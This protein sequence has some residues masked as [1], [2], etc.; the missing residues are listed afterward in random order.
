MAN[1]FFILLKKQRPICHCEVSI[2]VGP[3][4]QDSLRVL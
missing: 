2:G 4:T 1:D 3:N